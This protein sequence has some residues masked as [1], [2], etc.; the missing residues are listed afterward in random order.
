M[1]EKASTGAQAQIEDQYVTAIVV[2]HDGV[3]WLSEVVA[4]L[5]AQKHQP[6]EIIAV[7]NGST[8]DSVKFLNNA[9]IKVITISHRRLWL[10][11]C[12]RS[13]KITTSCN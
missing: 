12:C 7:D 2:T 13:S 4:A 8:D 6:D 5:S 3:T 9:G 10:C 1:A 11:S